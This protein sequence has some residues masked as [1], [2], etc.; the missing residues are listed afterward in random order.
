[1]DC[2]L[3]SASPEDLHTILVWAGTADLLRQ[4][5]GPALAFPATP[6]SA[7]AA[8]EASPDNAFALVDSSGELLGFGQ[9]SVQDPSVHLARLIVAPDRR[10]QGL[11]RIL[12]MKLIQAAITHHPGEITLKAYSSKAMAVPLFNASN[13]FNFAA[14]PGV[15]RIASFNR[16]QA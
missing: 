5:G 15:Q 13:A 10:G 8:I 16:L 6:D 1:M 11:G 9:A 12:A 2:S 14:M 3:R 4:W 7:W